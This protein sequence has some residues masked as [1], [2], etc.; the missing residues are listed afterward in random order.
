M[1]QTSSKTQSQMPFSSVNKAGDQDMQ[2]LRQLLLGADYD[3]LLRL[4]AQL[5]DPAQY[6]ESLAEVV[7]EAIAIRVQ[8]DDSVSD[9]LGPTIEGALGHSISKNPKALAD[10]L[11]PVMGPA[12]RKSIRE[13]MS[14]MFEGFNRAL[15]QSLSPKA[16]GWRF[17]AWRTGTQYSEVVLLNT[18]LFQV[19]QVFLIHRETGLLL[20]HITSPTAT[21]KDPDMVSGMLTAIQ[22]FV[23]DSFTVSSEDQLSTMKIGGV[24]VVVEQGPQAVIATAVRGEVPTDYRDLLI[25]ALEQCHLQYNSLLK[26]YEGDNSAFVLL[27]DILRPC[28]K[29]VKVTD[30]PKNRWPGFAISFVVLVVLFGLGYLELQRELAWKDTVSKLAAE[31]GIVVID[32][33]R[34]RNSAII[35]GLSDPL[36]RAPELILEEIEALNIPIEFEWQPYLSMEP[37]MVEQRLMRSIELPVGVTLSV[38]SRELSLHGVA[39]LN[40]VNQFL[41]KQD[42]L[43]GIDLINT[44]DLTI[45]DESI[46]KRNS[47]AKAVSKVAFYFDVGV[48]QIS[49]EDVVEVEAFADRLKTLIA[50][51]RSQQASL[52]VIVTGT[53]DA[54]GSSDL[55]MKLAQDRANNLIIH[56][57]ENGVPNYIFSV[58]TGV[59]EN[60]STNAT[61]KERSVTF[62]AVFKSDEVTQ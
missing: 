59:P 58:K 34:S 32:A 1:A 21:T 24:T 37:A 35:S 27:D 43:I 53:T 57:I 3:E 15:E 26:K 36:A 12:I 2:S 39:K 14:H 56:L 19:E 50:M 16:L 41:A 42:F 54:T 61:L 31:P 18:M 55:N 22:D 9:V 51:S 38:E 13:T 33:Q 8:Q 44:D 40:W 5:Q 6:S 11:Y 25:N 49:E 7:S 17:D 30:K 52:E 62:E 46:L 4:K 45:F 28:L 23:T 10:V 29:T 47:L 48:T 20:H 60:I